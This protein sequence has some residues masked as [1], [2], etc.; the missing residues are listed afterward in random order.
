MHVRNC[1]A[2]SSVHVAQAARARLQNKLSMNIPKAQKKVL[3]LLQMHLL[4][5]T[6]AADSGLQLELRADS[7]ISISNPVTYPTV[8]YYCHCQRHT[9]SARQL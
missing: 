8:Q 4:L 7:R 3:H 2:W 9:L 6:N 5:M 1:A